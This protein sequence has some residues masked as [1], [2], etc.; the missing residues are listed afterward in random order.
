MKILLTGFEPFLGL[1]TNPTAE[2]VTALDG[3]KIGNKSV[4][5][6]V[7]PVDFSG[8]KQALLAEIEALNPDVVLSLGLAFGRSCITPERI[9]I[10]C[11]DGEK[12]NAGVAYQDQLIE[13]EGPD[14][15]FSTLPVRKI[16]DALIAAKLPAKI[17]NTAGTYLCNQTMYV[18]RHYAEK[19][20]PALRA[21]FIHIPA[22]HKLALQKPMTS[23][24]S[25]QDLQRGIEIIIEQL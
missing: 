21:G 15:Y 13:K 3:M 24:W 7:L 11:M 23:S 20:N 4:H 22:D 18:A 9:A 8:T 12:D 16:V 6:S 10:N 17:S 14:G 1:E 2:I 5:G 25:L 19:N